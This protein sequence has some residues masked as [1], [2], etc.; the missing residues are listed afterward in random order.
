MDLE[1]NQEFKD[2]AIY[3]IDENVRMVSIALSKIQE[4]EI[5]TKQNRSLNTLGNMLLHICGNLKQYVLSSIGGEADDRDRDL[6]FEVEDGFSRDE[7]L[8]KLLFIT[9]SVNKTISEA[10]DE[11]LLTTYNVQGF[12]FSGI[13]AILHAVEHF[14][15]HTGQISF[16]VKLIID[17][18]LGFYAGMNLNARNDSTVEGLEDEL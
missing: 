4:E 2:N 15:Y 13:G 12:Q 8:Q 14:S 10:T 11:Q 3:R 1:W 9:S 6:E 18:P 7:L 16:Q 17:E 5:W